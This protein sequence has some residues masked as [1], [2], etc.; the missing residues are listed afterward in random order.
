M[1]RR[2]EGLGGVHQMNP[3]KYADL[4]GGHDVARRGAIKAPEELPE[5]TG[6]PPILYFQFENFYWIFWGC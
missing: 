3:E 2:E 1:A 6:N 5:E 4:Q